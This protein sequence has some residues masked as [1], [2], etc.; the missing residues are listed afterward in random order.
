MC[1]AHGTCQYHLHSL[2]ILEDVMKSDSVSNRDDSDI[3]DETITSKSN[4]SQDATTLDEE[5]SSNREESDISLLMKFFQDRIVTRLLI[6]IEH[7]HTSCQLYVAEDPPKNYHFSCPTVTIP[8]LFQ[9]AICS[10]NN[11]HMQLNDLI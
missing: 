3:P 7:P 6:V 2:V 10:Q 4:A 8:S 1:T 11:V 5:S 9:Q